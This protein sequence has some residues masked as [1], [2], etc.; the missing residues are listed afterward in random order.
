ME[1]RKATIG[2]MVKFFIKENGSIEVGHTEDDIKNFWEKHHRGPVEFPY[3][4]HGSKESIACFL[5]DDDN[6]PK[7]SDEEIRENDLVYSFYEVEF[8][9]VYENGEIY[10]THC[11]GEKLE[12]RTKA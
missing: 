11:N 5:A 6:G 4:L 10:I 3:W 7:L 2:E 8:N 1:D 9:C 12:N